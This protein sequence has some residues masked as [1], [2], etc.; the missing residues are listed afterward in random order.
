MNAK[1]ALRRKMKGMRDKRSGKARS[2]VG[3]GMDMSQMTEMIRMMADNP[4]LLKAVAGEMAPPLHSRPRMKPEEESEPEVTLVDSSRV[5][6]QLENEGLVCVAGC[7]IA[8]LDVVEY[9]IVVSSGIKESYTGCGEVYR[10]APEGNAT[11][12]RD[13]MGEI[14]V[15]SVLANK[16]IGSGDQIVIQIET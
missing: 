11:I 12:K 9:G 13:N 8:A 5:A 16:D 10:K 15:F 7:D 3:D 2:A 14:D 1:E 6:V 4:N